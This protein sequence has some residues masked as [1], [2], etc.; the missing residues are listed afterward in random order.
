MNVNNRQFDFWGMFPDLPDFMGM[1]PD[2]NNAN[3][4]VATILSPRDTLI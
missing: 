4:R 1:F 3:S 2:L